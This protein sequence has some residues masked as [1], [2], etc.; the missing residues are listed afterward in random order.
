ML[1]AWRRVAGGLTIGGLTVALACSG[2]DAQTNSYATLAEAD[3]AGAIVNGWMPEGLPPG[4][5]DIREG[6]V[7][8]THQR[9]GVIN[10]PQAQDAAL[11]ALLEPEE[12][13]LDGQ[14]CDVP[15]R[16]EWW[17]VILR[18]ALNGERL[19]ATQLRAY[20]ARQGNLIVA[21]NWNQGRAYYWTPPAS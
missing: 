1:K 10:F 5:H 7:P 6:H 8:G 15:G 3:Q 20:R 17:P 16:V 12:I 13:S 9:W 21:V 4:S 2:I 18:G 14:H 11:R 19:A